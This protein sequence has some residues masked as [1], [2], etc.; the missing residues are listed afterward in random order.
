MR[1]EEGLT[2]FSQQAI[3]RRDN[4]I[5]SGSPTVTM[6][7]LNERYECCSACSEFGGLICNMVGCG[8]KEWC[9]RKYFGILL[10]PKAKCPYL[11][12]GFKVIDG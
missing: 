4:R 5:K 6:G 3:L 12:S 1:V 11:D 8:T 9:V 7:Q 10:D 2:R